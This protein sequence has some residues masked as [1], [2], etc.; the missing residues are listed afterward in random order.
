MFCRFVP[1]HWVSWSSSWLPALPEINFPRRFLG[2]LVFLRWS[3][4][5]PIPRG[6]ASPPRRERQGSS[7]SRPFAPRIPPS[8]P[9]SCSPASSLLWP[10]LTSRPL[11]PQ[12]HGERLSLRA[13]LPCPRP[14]PPWFRTEHIHACDGSNDSG[15]PTHRSHLRGTS[16]CLPP[17]PTRSA[18]PTVISELNTVPAL[19]PVNA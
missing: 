15:E 16:Y 12:T 7:S 2:V 13:A 14:G 9:R 1:A 8:M 6:P 10:R 3:V 19:P 4:R 5:R 18:F 11:A 17:H